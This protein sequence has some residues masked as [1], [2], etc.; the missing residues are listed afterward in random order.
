[1]FRRT[2][3]KAAAA[4]ALALMI[5]APAADFAAAPAAQ[6]S[7]KTY[8]YA[9][10]MLDDWLAVYEKDAANAQ[11]QV[12]GK[13]TWRW[14]DNPDNG[15]GLTAETQRETDFWLSALIFDTFNDAY[16][17]SGD[18]RYVGIM[19]DLYNGFTSGNHPTW[20]VNVW[21]D[22]VYND[23]LCWW[24]NAFLRTYT[25]TGDAKYLATS[26][27]MFD[28]LFSYWDASAAFGGAPYGGILW[29]NDRPASNNEKNVA[30]N[31]NAALIAAR[32][33]KIYAGTDAAK[34]ATY[35]AD[36]K[37]IYDWAYAHL[38]KDK[39]T[40]LMI[41][42]ISYNGAESS[43]QFT[44]NYGLFADASYEMYTITGGQQYLDTA[45]KVLQY[46]WNTLTMSDGMTVKDEGQSD[47]A[48][49]KLVFMRA[50][51]DIVNNGGVADFAKYLTANA[52]Q[53]WRH[54]RPTDGLCGSNLSITPKFDTEIASP[55]SILG[56]ALLFYTG[57]DPNADPGY[58]LVDMA[59]GLNGVYQSEWA[60][61]SYIQFDSSQSGYTG[62]GYSQYWNSDG[63][64]VQDGW[65]RLDV[66]VPAGGVYK[67]DFR[68]FTR[69][70]NTRRISINGGPDALLNFTR[71][72]ANQWETV[73]YYARLNSGLNTIKLTYYNPSNHPSGADSDP[74]LFL[75]CLTA[76][77]QNPYPVPQ[78]SV[79][80]NGV[81]IPVN[82]TDGWDG[83]SDG[84]YVDY[85]VNV[86]KA[87]NY[88]LTFFY[89][90]NS[91]NGSREL[92]VNGVPAGTMLVFPKLGPGWS[93]CATA[94][95]YDVALS[96]GANT[97][98][99]ANNTAKGTSQ[100]INLLKYVSVAPAGV[101]V[102]Y[103]DA[104]R[105]DAGLSVNYTLSN[106]ENTAQA[107]SALIAVY[108]EGGRLSAISS[109]AV[110][111]APGEIKTFQTAVGGLAPGARYTAKVMMWG[112]S[113]NPLG[114]A[115][116]IDPAG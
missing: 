43:S 115:Y 42:N 93:Q 72:A 89:S 97:I 78:Q 57:A 29:R 44:Y 34:S 62:T 8:A 95:V 45:K 81:N 24:S 71:A 1:M 64:H 101:S 27:Q 58:S 90:N 23:D 10:K 106:N 11:G 52:Y 40:G 9:E 12:V 22:D 96:A 88:A 87:G 69:G 33:S 20:D 94:R 7:A 67:L 82:Y 68:W 98:R 70:D 77:Y 30:T 113:Y 60:A 99:V 48:G 37:Q 3:F 19:N 47:S 15:G 109:P 111:L 75:D 80:A 25:L 54:R 108:D 14:S 92:I 53:A 46:G 41:D 32:L 114:G 31:G 103:A 26:T 79:T 21:T 105:S 17:Y 35:A 107:F 83:G 61:N 49:F 91:G 6:D 73:S 110:S 51:A 16:Q 66:N 56:P 85:S 84:P 63:P 65:I 116:A 18:T 38:Y 39:S 2:A 74:W 4:C 86:P 36:A 104:S 102:S 100:Y 55:C 112:A 5:A 59:D 50:T 76:Y 28:K 13:S